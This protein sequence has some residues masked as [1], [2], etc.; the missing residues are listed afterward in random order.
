[1]VSQLSNRGRNF[2]L[3]LA[4]LMIRRVINRLIILML[5]MSGSNY[6]DLLRVKV[7]AWLF[8][9]LSSLGLNDMNKLPSSDT[10]AAQTARSC[11]AR[12]ELLIRAFPLPPPRTIKFNN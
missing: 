4:D 11:R 2:I 5:N 10:A 3:Q 7:Q 12:G 1:M 6:S 8:F 9:Q